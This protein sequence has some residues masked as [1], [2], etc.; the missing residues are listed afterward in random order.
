MGSNYGKSLMNE[1]TRLKEELTV[2][3]AQNV[4]LTEENAALRKENRLLRNDNERM[5]R[6]LNND[7]SN[8]STPTSANQPGQQRLKS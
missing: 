1:N 2:V 3:K 7:S 6:I 8:S 5:K 4:M